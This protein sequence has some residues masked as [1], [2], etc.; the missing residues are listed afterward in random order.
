[1][2]EAEELREKI[3]RYN[4]AWNRHDVD[5]IVALH[6]PDFVFHNWT[7]NEQVE[8]DAVRDHVAR[9][10][11]NT[12]SLRFT[13]RRLYARDGLVVSEWTAH[14]ER[15]GKQVEWDGIDVFP[16]ENGLIKRKDVYSSSHSP[17]TRDG[18][19]GDSGRE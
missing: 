7:A 9:I 16:F 4:D 11:R 2:S 17:R 15:D 3:E 14:A 8:G 12:P 1:M 10:F 5:A 19:E 13:G 18:A 6:A